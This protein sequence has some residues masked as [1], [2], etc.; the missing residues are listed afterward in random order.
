MLDEERIL[1]LKYYLNL[2]HKAIENKC[3]SIGDRTG[4]ITLFSYSGIVIYLDALN[5]INEKC[6]LEFSRDKYNECT[7]DNILIVKSFSNFDMEFK[8][9]SFRNHILGDCPVCFESFSKKS[10]KSGN[11]GH[12]LCT[13]C[14]DKWHTKCELNY[15]CPICRQ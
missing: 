8:I 3:S 5:F 1:H 11:C 9:K 4:H 2:Y 13:D 6:D 14:C 12:Y 15:T 7:T 10:S